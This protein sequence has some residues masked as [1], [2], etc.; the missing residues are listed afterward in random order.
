MAQL[1]RL[2]WA[3]GASGVC[4]GV[5]VGLRVTDETALEAAVGR[6]PPGW[7][8]SS[9]PRAD[10]V[11]SFVVGGTG[12]RPGVRR[13]HLLYADARLVA[14]TARGEEALNALESEAR[15]YVAERARG[16]VFVHAG[17]VGGKGRA[18]VI[19]GRS[20]TGKSRLVHALVQEG[21]TYYS[22][23]Y[24]VLDGRGRVHAFPAP[25]SIRAEPGTEG[26]RIPPEEL[27][28]E[29][30]SPP[31]PVGLVVVGSYAR[32]R[33]TRLRPASTAAAAL[34]LLSNAVPARRRPAAVLST[35]SKVARRA[36]ALSGTRGEAQEA[37]RHLLA[38]EAA[39]PEEGA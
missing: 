9:D 8:A 32:G 21:A 31:L 17:V 18:I 37:A 29:A 33:R 16:R 14:R 23:E 3:A 35:L 1:D 4:Y 28:A 38:V 10:R 36:P 19:P 6:L 7:A 5:R 11:F 13:M 39:W 24:A 30:G 22:D 34:A 12:Q 20:H 2:V 26:R 27:G 15:L 25:L